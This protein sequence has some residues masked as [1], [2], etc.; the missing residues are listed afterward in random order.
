ME[1]AKYI[2]ALR[3]YAGVG[4]KTF[5]MLTMRF[6]A[7]ENILRAEVEELASLPRISVEK[8]KKIV[9][10]EK[11]L[12]EADETLMELDRQGVNVMTLMDEDYPGPLTQLS[13]P[14]PL[15]YYKGKFESQDTPRVA[16]VGTTQASQEGLRYASDIAKRLSELGVTVVS[17]LARGIDTAAH[18]ATLNS[19]G[20]TYAALGSG[21]EKIYPPENGRL[22]ELVAENGVLLSEF[23]PDIPVSVGNL[24]SRNRIVVGLS[25]GV[26]VVEMR[27]ENLDKSGSMNAILRAHQQEKPVYIVDPEGR[28]T[29]EDQRQSNTQTIKGVEDIDTI[30]RY[31]V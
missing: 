5:Q 10:A 22:A 27:Q 15:F 13:D 9:G 31:L 2:L 30:V 11:H 19:N 14:P 12:E 21:F 26:I 28:L 17:G 24:M 29:S 1:R 4:P 16:V 8:A 25:Q 23:L 18:L 7:T 6:G 3:H 20:K